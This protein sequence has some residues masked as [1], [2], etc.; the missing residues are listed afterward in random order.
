MNVFEKGKLFPSFV[1]RADVD[2]INYEVWP[3]ILH[4]HI[5]SQYCYFQGWKQY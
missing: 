5:T 3:I 4:T 2:Q 1:W